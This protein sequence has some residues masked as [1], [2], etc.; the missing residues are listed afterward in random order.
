[1][2]SGGISYSSATTMIKREITSI[3]ITGRRSKF[4]NSGWIGY[5]ERQ[6]SMPG[7]FGFLWG[8]PLSQLRGSQWRGVPCILFWCKH[9]GGKYLLSL[10]LCFYNQ[11]YPRKLDL[12]K[13]SMSIQKSENSV[14]VCV[15]TF[16][17]AAHWGALSVADRRSEGE[18]SCIGFPLYSTLSRKIHNMWCKLLRLKQQFE[19]I[20]PK[21]YGPAYVNLGLKFHKFSKCFL[22]FYWS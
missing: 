4:L 18:Q 11:S 13:I 2:R 1:M 20:K 12:F 21:E 3:M 22:N 5:F 14:W 6:F 16:A 15:C 7:W 9:E 19:T 8:G 17:L 10:W